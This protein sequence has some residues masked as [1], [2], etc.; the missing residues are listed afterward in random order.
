ME[1]TTA[2]TSLAL[3]GAL[4]A[5][6]A[7]VHATTGREPSPPRRFAWTLVL[8]GVAAMVVL[9]VFDGA[10]A[11]G[12]GLAGALALTRL[13][14]TPLRRRDLVF[15]LAALGVG[16]ACGVQA[17]TSA[18]FGTFLFCVAATWLWVSPPVLRD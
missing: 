6:I 14:S 13:C 1:W 10:L 7:W 2:A 12:A 11:R 9:L 18:I 3:G 8:A 15:A 16:A 17:F 4:S 5:T